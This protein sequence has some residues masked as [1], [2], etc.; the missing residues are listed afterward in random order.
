VCV[1]DCSGMGTVAMT[2]LI[3]L[4]NIALGT[5]QPAACANGLPIG[6]EIDIAAIIG[7]VNNALNGCAR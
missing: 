3:T 6:G 4:V 5:A 1:G 2:D 7:A